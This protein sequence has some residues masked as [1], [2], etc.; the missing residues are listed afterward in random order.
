[1]PR[2]SSRKSF[3]SAYAASL[4]EL[5][6]QRNQSELIRQELADLKQLVLDNRTFALF[7][8]D[9]AIGQAQRA[10]TL[11]RVFAGRLSTL[12]ESFLAVLNR[13]NRLAALPQ[14][15]DAY[16]QLLDQQ[17]GKVQVDVVVAQE[18]DQQLA[19]EVRNKVSAALKKQAVLRQTVDDSIIGGLVLR[20]QDKLIDASVRTQLAAMKRQLLSAAGRK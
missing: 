11:K 14:I 2:A 9:P 17:L 5:A 15:A 10:E 4:L 12:M 18:L 1:M 16:S 20:V 19:D 6:N 7:L 3:A 8:A 13:R